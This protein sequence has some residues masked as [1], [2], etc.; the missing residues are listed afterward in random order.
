MLGV[1]EGRG[2]F[3]GA[4]PT[5]WG[6]AACAGPPHLPPPSSTPPSV[7]LRGEVC[8]LKDPCPAF[9]ECLCHL[10]FFKSI[11]ISSMIFPSSQPVHPKQ[12]DGEHEDQIAKKKIILS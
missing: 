8:P 2:G 5:Q 3:W 7:A 1:V 10:L 12:E 4:P 11:F 6:A 9:C